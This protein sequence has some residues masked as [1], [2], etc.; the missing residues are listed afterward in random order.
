MTSDN[1]MFCDKCGRPIPTGKGYMIISG[2]IICGI[3]Q[4][5]NKPIIYNP[6]SPKYDGEEAQ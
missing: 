1:T 5:D 6:M 2:W 4:L 3:C